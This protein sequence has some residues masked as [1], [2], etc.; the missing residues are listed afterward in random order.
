LDFFDPKDGEEKEIEEEKVKEEGEKGEKVEGEEGKV[1]ETDGSTAK[2]EG[3]ARIYAKIWSK[4]TILFRRKTEFFV[5]KRVFLHVQEGFV[6]F[7]GH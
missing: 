4:L 1:E 6:A 7:A 5:E 2:K 3:F